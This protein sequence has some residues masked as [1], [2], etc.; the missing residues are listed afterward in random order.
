MDASP[1]ATPPITVPVAPPGVSGRN[2]LRTNH[3]HPLLTAAE[4]EIFTLKSNSQLV[5]AWIFF[6]RFCLKDPFMFALVK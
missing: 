2:S 3:V 1:P 6:Y 4:N 5:K